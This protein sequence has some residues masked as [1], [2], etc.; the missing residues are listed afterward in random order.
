METFGTLVFLNGQPFLEL[1]IGELVQL[2]NSFTVEDLNG[3]P[4]IL[5][6]KYAGQQIV[7]RKAVA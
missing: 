5:D 6:D 1:E 7:I 2:N 3:Q 4:I